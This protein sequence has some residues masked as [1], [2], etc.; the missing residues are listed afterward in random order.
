MFGADHMNV[1]FDW[2]GCTIIVSAVKMTPETGV[3][4]VGRSSPGGGASDKRS[5]WSIEDP[6]KWLWETWSAPCVR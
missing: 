4:L 6:G 2:V 1:N 5:Q 3:G